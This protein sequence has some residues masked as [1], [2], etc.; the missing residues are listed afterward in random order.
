VYNVSYILQEANMKLSLKKNWYLYVMLIAG[1]LILGAAL[2]TYGG[3]EGNTKEAGILSEATGEASATGE[4]PSTS[5]PTDTPDPQPTDTPEPSPAPTAE[6]TN[7]PTA[8]PETKTIHLKA[9]ATVEVPYGTEYCG[10]KRSE[11]FH[12][13]WCDSVHDIKLSNF[14]I[15]ESREDAV[16]KG[17]RPCK[18]CEP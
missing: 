9:G 16:A 5:S 8:E 18:R 7:E 6:P 14:V 1:I 15:Y 4:E 17:K 10:S 13:I 11:V 2:K 12:Y 3:A